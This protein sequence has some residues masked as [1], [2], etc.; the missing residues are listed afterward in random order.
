MYENISR[1]RIFFFDVSLMPNDEVPH[2]CKSGGGV[3]V[4]H[5]VACAEDAVV[6]KAALGK[7]KERRKEC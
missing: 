7:E 3:V 2:V 4:G 6:A 5:E 1:L